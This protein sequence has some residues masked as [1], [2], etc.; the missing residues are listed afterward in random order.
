L[1]GGQ[2]EIIS[3]R[4]SIEEAKANLFEASGVFIDVPLSLPYLPKLPKTIQA[5]YTLAGKVNPDVKAASE[6]INQA[7]QNIKTSQ[8]ERSP[9]IR[10]LGD[11]NI[12]RDTAFNGFERDEGSLRVQ[13]TVPI[14]AGGALAS[15]ERSS[16]LAKSGAQIDRVRIINRVRENVASSWS[17]LEASRGL[18]KIN[19]DLVHI[20]EEA[21]EAVK[22]EADA[23]FRPNLDVLNSQQELLEAR[24]A[25]TAAR[26]NEVLSAYFLLGSIGELDNKAYLAC[27]NI[28]P[29]IRLEEQRLKLEGPQRFIPSIPVKPARRKK[30]TGPRSRR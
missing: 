24:L 2:A 21:A 12:Q 27:Q 28:L 15:R 20:A 19:E 26:Y 8:G 25:L 1:Q 11:L 7:E 14:F 5:A 29:N 16:V 9:E 10:L 6:T 3:A 23:G 4:Q 22:K 30:K 13:M 18:I 17:N